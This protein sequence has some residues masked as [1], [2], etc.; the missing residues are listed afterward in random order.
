MTLEEDGCMVR[1]RVQNV[2]QEIWTEGKGT[3]ERG[4]SMSKGPKAL[5]DMFRKQIPSSHAW[6]IGNWMGVGGQSWRIEKG[7]GD[8]GS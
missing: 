8:Q 3:S 5:N 2:G 6:I 4:N 1:M 7:P